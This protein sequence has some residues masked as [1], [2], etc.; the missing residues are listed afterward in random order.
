M[1]TPNRTYE[2]ATVRERAN[3]DPTVDARGDSRTSGVHR[4]ATVRERANPDPTVDARGDS[5]TSGR[6]ASSSTGTWGRRAGVVLQAVLLACWMAGAASAEITDT[7]ATV[8]ATVQELIDATPASLNSHQQTLGVDSLEPPLSAHASLTSTN[9]EGVLV[10]L[11]QG[12][13]HFVDPTRLDQPNP[14]ELGA[15]VACYSNARSVSY[16]VQ[17]SAVESRTVV[18]SPSQIEF[19]DD[20]TQTMESRVFLSG[21]VV[22]W[23][24]EPGRNLDEM[25]A[26]LRVSVM[27]ADTGETLFES[28]LLLTGAA[29]AEVRTEVI[30]PIR[31]EVVSLDDLLAEGADADSIAILE[32]VRAQGTLLIVLLGPQE[33]TYTYSVTP[34]DAFI[35]TATF[36][37]RVRN[38]PDGTGVAAVLGRPF[39]NLAEFI[40][41]GL[42]GVNGQAVQRSLND[43]TAKR[44]LGLVP[45]ATSSPLRRS[46]ALCGAFGLEFL[47]LLPL[48]IAPAVIPRRDRKG[49]CRM[50]PL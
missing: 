30:G 44:A 39:Q 9:L 28:T 35:L 21:A 49:A 27:R 25:L 26:E 11:G 22:F 46:G 48:W 18:F 2:D 3:P 17:S 15:E 36:E 23:S 50:P 40:E 38:I 37:A 20:G 5:R 19:N 1:K 41:L 8:F 31:S 13:G 45:T 7:G 4:D 43:A 10:S 47:A 42:P 16:S 29:A 24:T 12:F 32:Q 6:G 33:H 14:E 34:D